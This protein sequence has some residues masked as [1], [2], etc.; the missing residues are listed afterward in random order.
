MK[1]HSKGLHATV[2]FFFFW[3]DRIGYVCIYMYMM[4]DYLADDAF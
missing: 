2:C 4:V 1:V 3:L